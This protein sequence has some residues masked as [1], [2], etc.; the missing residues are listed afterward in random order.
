MRTDRKKNNTTQFWNPSVCGFFAA[1]IWLPDILARITCSSFGFI[2]LF[3]VF[4]EVQLYITSLIPIATDGQFRPKYVFFVRLVL[5]SILFREWWPSLHRAPS[6]KTEGERAI[7]EKAYCLPRPS[8]QNM[9][10]LLRYLISVF[11]LFRRHLFL[12]NFGF[13]S[14]LDWGNLKSLRSLRSLEFWLVRSCRILLGFDD[15]FGNWQHVSRTNANNQ[16]C[17]H[18]EPPNKTRNNLHFHR[19]ATL[20][21]TVHVDYYPA[22][23]RPV[24]RS[25]KSSDDLFIKKLNA[26]TNQIIGQKRKPTGKAPEST[27]LPLRKVII[28]WGCYLYVLIITTDQ[29]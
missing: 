24:Q 28:Y 8:A 17:V 6:W 14:C 25:N 1:S 9:C 5:C 22:H 27:C 10:A 21:I 3:T 11:C 2:C 19:L 23:I 15:C 20:R 26:A 13:V 7:T 29:P 12:I 4:S 18:S 16:N